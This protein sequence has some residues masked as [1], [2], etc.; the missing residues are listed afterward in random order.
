MRSAGSHRS[1][2]RLV[3]WNPWVLVLVLGQ[4]DVGVDSL[5]IIFKHRSLKNPAVSPFLMA[6]AEPRAQNRFG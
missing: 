2:G 1:D 4:P 6:P 5:S 3:G